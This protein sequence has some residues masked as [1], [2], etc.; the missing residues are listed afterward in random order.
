MSDGDTP[1][2]W[3]GSS[4]DDLSAFPRKVKE[5]MGFALRVGF[6]G[7]GVLEIIEDFDGNTYRGVYT[8][9]MKG[10]IYVL[11]AF[12]KKSKSGIKTPE[13][14]IK[15]IHQRLKMAEQAYAS[16][17]KE[18]NEKQSKGRKKQR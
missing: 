15:K 13:F 1:I 11:H 4:R 6:G 10:A 16:Q 8:V 12:Q 9:K 17:K 2:K 14:E 3:V 5:T 18:A 7:A